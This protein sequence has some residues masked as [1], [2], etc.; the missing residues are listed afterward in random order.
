M[1]SDDKIYFLI[2]PFTQIESLYKKKTY[3][4][5]IGI[6]MDRLYARAIVK[7]FTQLKRNSKIF[8]CRFQAYKKWIK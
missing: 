2:F 5:Y 8:T 3:T 6:H 4:N 7:F 1:Y